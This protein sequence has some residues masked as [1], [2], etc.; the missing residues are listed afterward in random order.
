MQQ[1][2]DRRLFERAVD[3]LGTIVYVGSQGLAATDPQACFAEE[4][5]RLRRAIDAFRATHAELTEWMSSPS[6]PDQLRLGNELVAAGAEDLEVLLSGLDEADRRCPEPIPTPSR[7]PP[8]SP[9]VQKPPG[10]SPIGRV[11]RNRVGPRRVAP[12]R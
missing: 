8:P 6:D 1:S 5:R 3:E 7:E 10:A 2:G 11:G 9:P 4:Y 12:R